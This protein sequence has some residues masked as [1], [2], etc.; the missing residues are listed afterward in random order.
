MR[1]RLERWGPGDFELLE[2]LVGDPAMM[3]HLGGPESPEK[4]RERQKRYEGTDTAFKVADEESGE[5][6]GWVGYWESDDAWEIGWAVVPEHQGKGIASE[7]TRLALERVQQ[8]GSC[9]F[10]HAF[11]DVNNE[12][13]NAICRKLG[14]TLLGQIDGE[15]PPGQPRR[16]N[17]WRYDLEDEAPRMDP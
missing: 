15:Y 9:R 6:V 2:R 3:E 17:D 11:P 1:V 12:A 16:F 14:F 4:I 8:N 7:A 13:S 10:V 5:G